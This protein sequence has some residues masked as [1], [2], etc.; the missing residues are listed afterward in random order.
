MIRADE[1]P[2]EIAPILPEKQFS[3]ADV[4]S[5]HRSLIKLLEGMLSFVLLWALK[6]G[7][8]C[9]ASST[10]S[11]AEERCLFLGR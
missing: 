9:S 5:K 6:S 2:H 8:F 4:R 1:Q 10:C 7:A 11:K 3:P